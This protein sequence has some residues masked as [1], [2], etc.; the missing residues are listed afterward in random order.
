MK[1]ASPSATVIMGDPPQN[2]RQNPRLPPP[3]PVAVQ[4]PPDRMETIA[5][6]VALPLIS[7]V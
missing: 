5:N 1:G 4:P 6:L 3:T 2:C 7:L